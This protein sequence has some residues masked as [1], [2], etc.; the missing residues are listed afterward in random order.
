MKNIIK[1]IKP[2]KLSVLLVVALLIVQAYCDLGLPAYTSDIIDIGIQSGGIEH[3]LP[4]E[5]KPD[6][7]ERAELFMDD[8]ERA[9]WES[10]YEKS[11]DSGD[12][13]VLT[14]SEE[15]LGA[16]QIGRASCRER[17]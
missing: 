8:G 1:F 4:K 9:A 17:V 10:A 3:I 6:E 16:D 15:E 7:Y 5:V 12:N 13:Y 14:V 2:Y 11:G